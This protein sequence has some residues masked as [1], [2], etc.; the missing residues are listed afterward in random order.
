MSVRTEHSSFSI[1]KRYLSLIVRGGIFFFVIYFLFWKIDW[2]P[3][4]QV[5]TALD[6]KWGALSVLCFFFTLGMKIIRWRVLLRLV[7]GNSQ[8]ITLRDLV[9]PFFVGQA[10]N[11]IMP[12]RGGEALRLSWLGMKDKRLMLPGVFS[13]LLEKWEDL[14]FLSLL[15]FALGPWASKWINFPPIFSWFIIGIVLFILGISFWGIRFFKLQD[16][17]FIPKS[18]REILESEIGGAQY[19]LKLTVN[20]LNVGFLSICYS[21]L[22]WGSMVLTNLFALRALFL[23]MDVRIAVT[24]LVFVYVALVPALIPGNIGPFH[25]AV[26]LGMSL[27][28]I[29]LAQSLSFAVLLHGIVTVPPL[30]FSALIILWK[31]W[32]KP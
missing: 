13:V 30:L 14:L 18:I 10:V 12:F 8:M 29:P 31:R 19:R 7:G 20:H 26:V 23:P 25:G 15:S 6:W 32:E 2:L 17:P 27:F 21:V 5:L 22:I 3:V 24:I 4:F 16:I 1:E 28:Q 11:I 9:A